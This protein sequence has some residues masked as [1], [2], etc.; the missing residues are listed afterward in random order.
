[1]VSAGSILVRRSYDATG[2]KRMTLP[3]RK[4]TVWV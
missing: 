2:Q 3:D 4:V 1:M